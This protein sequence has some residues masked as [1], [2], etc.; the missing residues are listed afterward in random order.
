MFKV[1]F[2]LLVI[3]TIT[4]PFALA[5]QDLSS[6]IIKLRSEVDSLSED[7]KTEKELLK[8]KIQNLAIEK[9]DLDSKIRREKIKIKAQEQKINKVEKP[10]ILA[11]EDYNLIIKNFIN[12]EYSRVSSSLPYKRKERLDYL[13]TLIKDF[14]KGA[15][16]AEKTLQF[17][18]THVEDEIQLAKDVLLDRDFVQIENK[19]K[20]VDVARVGMLMMF[21]KTEDNK[22]GYIKYDGLQWKP[23]IFKLSQNEKLVSDFFTNLKKQ[24][25]AGFFDFPQIPLKIYE[26][27]ELR[28][29]KSGAKNENV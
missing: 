22:Y 7:L 21:F 20:I 2:V 6:Q 17:L 12:E 11:L 9:M 16:T 24:I 28:N 18:W 29:A 26:K 8:S 5:S 27:Q 23:E 10:E 14:E 1:F 4:F 15:N 13:D 3:F 25:K 19:E